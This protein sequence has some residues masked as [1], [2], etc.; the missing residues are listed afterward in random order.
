M[1]PGGDALDGS[2]QGEG[3]APPGSELRLGLEPSLQHAAVGPELQRSAP[4]LLKSGTTTPVSN[5][6]VLH[7]TLEMGQPEHE[8]KQISIYSLRLKM[9]VV[10]PAGS[11]SEPTDQDL[12]DQ[13]RGVQSRSWR[14]GVLHVL[15][16]S[17]L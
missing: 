14:A 8:I 10:L 2:P 3:S 15:D 4:N 6:P 9:I 5:V 16:A 7:V 12:S 1:T 13:N 17:L 11:A